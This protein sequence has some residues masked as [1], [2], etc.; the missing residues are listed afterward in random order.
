MK[1]RTILYLFAGITGLLFSCSDA[2]IVSGNYHGTLYAS[3]TVEATIKI[4]EVNEGYIRLETTSPQM[5]QS[6]I[7]YAKLQKNSADAYNLYGANP[8][9]GYHLTGYYYESFLHVQSISNGYMFEGTK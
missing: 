4:F 7:D 3:D 8:S 6:Y 2:K 1:T 5:N 9:G